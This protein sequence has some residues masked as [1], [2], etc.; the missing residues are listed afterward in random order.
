MR[1][2]TGTTGRDD[3][4]GEGSAPRILATP[5]DPDDVLLEV[6]LELAVVTG[7]AK[8]TKRK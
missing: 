3:G 4:G 6:D 2:G 7:L 5:I 8:M 1:M